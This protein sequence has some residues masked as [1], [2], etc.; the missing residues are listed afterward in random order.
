LFLGHNIR[1]TN[2]GRPIKDSKDADFCLVFK[3]RKIAAR[4]W[5][6]GPDDVNMQSLNLP[7][8][9]RHPQNISNPK[10]PKFLFIE[11]ARHPAFFESLNNSLPQSVG[12][13]WP[14]AEMAQVTIC[15][16]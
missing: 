11:S 14:S 2:A 10:L 13:L 1:I 15:G 9:V 8:I 5:S 3:K 12:E 4:G 6:P 7:L 16:T